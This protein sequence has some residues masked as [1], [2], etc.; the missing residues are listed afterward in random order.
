MLEQDGCSTYLSSNSDIRYLGLKA[1]DELGSLV[2]EQ[3]S[4]Y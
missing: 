2:I 3:L 4:M 1:L